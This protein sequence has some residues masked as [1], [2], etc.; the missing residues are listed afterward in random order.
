MC[1][2]LL[3]KCLTFPAASLSFLDLIKLMQIKAP[4]INILA[5]K[6]FS[7][8]KDVFVTVKRMEI[9]ESMKQ[10]MYYERKS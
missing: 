2:L 9:K 8:V 1:Q 10:N 6:H 4:W 3:K 7:Y 5:A